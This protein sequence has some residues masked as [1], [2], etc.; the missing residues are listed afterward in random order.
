MNGRTDD[1]L[2]DIRL[3]VDYD[4]TLV[5]IAK[6]PELATP[7]DEVL[8]LLDALAG[9]RGLRV[10]IVSGRAFPSLDSWFGYL[11]IALW[12]EHGFWHRA[13]PGKLWEPAGR[14]PHD[15]MQ[16]ITPILSE[17]TASTPGSHVE[18]KSVSIAWHYRLAEP[19][20]AARRAQVLRSRLADELRD[21][22][23]DVLEGKKVIEV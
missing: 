4:G 7:D 14:V 2:L 16:P 15:W 17:V 18:R 21:L 9:R 11:P 10:A 6:S 1:E 3:L 8:A 20:L 19:A 13:G 12:A 5:P 22:P 23:L